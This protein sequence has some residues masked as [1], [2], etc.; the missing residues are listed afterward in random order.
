MGKLKILAAGDSAGAQAN[1]RGHLF[2]KLMAEVL[3]HYG[4]KIDNAFNVNYSGMEIDIEGSAIVTN[5]KI[6]AEC[7]CYEKEIDAPKFCAFYGKYMSR[8]RKDPHCQGLFIAIPGINGPAKGFYN[9]NCLTDPEIT[10]RVLNEEDVIQSIIESELA[11]R[12][13]QLNKPSFSDK[14]DLGECDI[15]YTDKGLFWAQYLIY[16]GVGI[17]TAI[18]LFDAR[19]NVI[20]DQHIIDYILNLDSEYLNFEI[21]KENGYQQP[22]DSTR[23]NQYEDQ[24]VE[25]RGSSE[26]FEYQFPASP[27]YFIGRKSEKAEIESFLDKVIEKETS[28]RGILLEANSGWGKSSFALTCVDIFRRKGHYALAI[29]SRTASS[30]QFVLKII[31]HT[32]NKFGDFNGSVSR[33]VI[34]SNISGFEG[35]IN[36]LL[37]IGQEL[38]KDK[39]CLLIFLDQFESIF[40]NQDALKRIRD[41]YF[42]LSDN[43]TNVII[44]FSWKSDLVG[45]TKDFPYEIRDAIKDSSKR[46]PLHTFDDKDTMDMLKRLEAEF[47]PK[48]KLTK[49][50]QF[51]LSYF[52]QGYPWTLKKL[53]AHVKS[54][55]ES[56]LSQ[57]DI[58]TRLLNIQNLFQ[59]DLERL[60][61]EE[62]DVLERIAKISPISNKELYSE[63]FNPKVVQS[64][65]NSRLLVNIGSKYD[66]YWDIFKD[67]INTRRVPIQ[68]NY[69][70]KLSPGSIVRALYILAKNNGKMG[71]PE[72]INEAKLTKK[73]FYNM[74]RDIRLLDLAKI[75]E[76]T[77]ALNMRFPT[78]IDNFNATLKQKIQE[79]IQ[80]NRLVKIILDQINT[81][82]VASL[83]EIS[84]L[85]ANSCPYINA[86]KDTW[87]LYTNV[88]L[89]WIDYAN[90]A[91]YNKQ[92]KE[93]KP[94]TSGG[95]TRRDYAILQRRRL[96]ITVPPTQYEPIEKFAVEIYK[97][98]KS[99]N[100]ISSNKF[101]NKKFRKQLLALEYL[102]F[103]WRHSDVIEV[104]PSLEEFVENPELRSKIFAEAALKID[105]FNEFIGMLNKK[106]RKTRSL[107][108]LI[109][110]FEDITNVQ[111]A[112]ETAK[113]S[114]KILLNWARA[115]DLAPPRFK[116]RRKNVI[117]R[118]QMFLI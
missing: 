49:D 44:G 90:L 85:I 112:E 59:E 52:S 45:S 80:Y 67:F 93:I 28:S 104:N 69:L 11:A 5:T 31:E 34:N 12:P 20:N 65:V 96:S 18:A 43:Q 25:V 36:Q 100:R 62:R 19:G 71:I 7:K 14:V 97:E 54:Q 10:I 27:E 77:I 39:K 92:L 89:A 35:G 37:R 23:I 32:I 74:A 38:E 64:L 82:D 33:H 51:F 57:D 114:I 94:L 17:P 16:K 111:W 50:L 78:D 115:A 48:R 88:L 81:K 3:R 117:T 6:Y 109:E 84:E 2:E 55:I 79:K 13:G 73:S 40:F 107:K 72:F 29:D 15:L 76:D 113:W 106:P 46:I 66:I 86:S 58:S 56:G 68:E 118:D 99:G 101:S 98:Y 91:I 103:I 108:P 22:Q 60:S 110:E 47:R 21:I 75:D 8:W 102:G 9:D 41:L 105:I 53:C 1:A 4:Y 63:D 26:C 83:K 24:I 30:S 61:P 95:E 87:N 70:L 116:I 42:K